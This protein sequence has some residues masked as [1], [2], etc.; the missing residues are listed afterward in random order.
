MAIKLSVLASGSKGNSIYVATDRV[1]LLI[2]AGLSGREIER[3]LL[4]IGASP[5]DLDGVVLTH[6]HIDHVRGV[7]SLARSYQL[8]VYLNERT[9]AH[10]PTVVGKLKEKEEFVAGRT[11]CI[12]DITIHPFAISHDAADPVGFTLVNG[13]VKLGV[14]TDLG[15]ST[16]LVHRHLDECSVL[17]LEANH[18]V[19]MLNTGPYPWSLKQRIRSRMGH[20]SN[21]QSAQIISQVF[22]P[23][24]HQVVLAHMSETNNCAAMVQ[25][26]FMR[27]LHRDMQAELRITLASQ[28]LPTELVE[29]I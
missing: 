2:D 10:L 27:L 20:L 12:E 5:R 23:R 15:A 3:R 1:R 16:K 24:L 19:E 9:H 13:S 25:E 7:G 21:E 29:L 11:Y 6:E 4:S 28:H 26:T 8:P 17:I 18:D 14:C 22:N